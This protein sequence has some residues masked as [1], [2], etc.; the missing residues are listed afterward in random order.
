MFVLLMKWLEELVSLFS[1]CNMHG[2]SLICLITR[3]VVFLY[4]DDNDNYETKIDSQ[5]NLF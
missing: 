4:I 3:N 1:I 2:H 5:A